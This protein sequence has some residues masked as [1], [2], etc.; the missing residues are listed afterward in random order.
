MECFVRACFKILKLPLK[1]FQVFFFLKKTRDYLKGSL[2]E[3]KTIRND[4]QVSG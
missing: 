1:K 2:K 3:A 4:L